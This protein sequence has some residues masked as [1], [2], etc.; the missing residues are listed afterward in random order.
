MKKGSQNTLRAA[1]AAVLLLIFGLL[2]SLAA[3]KPQKR[4]EIILSTPQMREAWLNLRGWRVG[5]PEVTETCIPAAW[6]TDAGQRWLMLQAEQGFSPESYAGKQAARYLY[7]VLNAPNEWYMAELLL[8]G[9]TLIAASV[10][11]ASTQV[12]QKVR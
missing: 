8:C 12:M 2:F 5:T 7:P 6:E 3:K 11:D 10:Y 4:D 9:D 1:A